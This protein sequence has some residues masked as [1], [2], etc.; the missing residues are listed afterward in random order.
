VIAD[1]VSVVL[2]TA[3]PLAKRKRDNVEDYVCKRSIL[4]IISYS[5]NGPAMFM[6]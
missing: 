3:F 4:E 1:E 5:G 2:L 6:E